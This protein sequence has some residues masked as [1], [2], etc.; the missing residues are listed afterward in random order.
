MRDVGS[1]VGLQRA[2]SIDEVFLEPFEYATKLRL[3]PHRIKP[4]AFVIIDEAR[5]CG[6]QLRIEPLDGIGLRLQNG[7][8][9]AGA[10]NGKVNTWLIQRPNALVF[11]FVQTD[12]VPGY[13]IFI[14]LEVHIAAQQTTGGTAIQ[15]APS[16]ENIVAVDIKYQLL[17]PRHV[18]DIGGGH[19]V[20]ERIK[21]RIVDPLAVVDKPLIDRVTQQ[22]A[23]A[24]GVQLRANTARHK[25]QH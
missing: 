11:Q 1:N 8:G 10:D 13:L 22:S 4:V 7:T 2:S 18:T 25:C 24:G 20:Y 19:L 12:D 17:F 21:I 9:D 6:I 16:R 5:C 23:P 15:N 3:A 14:P